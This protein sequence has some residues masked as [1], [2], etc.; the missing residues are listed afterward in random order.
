M[1][2]MKKVEVEA[3]DSVNINSSEGK[4]KDSSEGKIKEIS[5]KKLP[6]PKVAP[7][8]LVGSLQVLLRYQVFN[9]ELTT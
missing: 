8:G 6:P 7:L 1:K 4:I 5:S 2:E 9:E 3:Q